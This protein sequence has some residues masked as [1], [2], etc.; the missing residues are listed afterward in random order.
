ML[1]SWLRTQTPLIENAMG[2]Q[3]HDKVDSHKTLECVKH[4]FRKYEFQKANEYYYKMPFGFEIVISGDERMPYS[5]WR[6]SADTQ[7]KLTGI[8]KCATYVLNAVPIDQF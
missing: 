3:F 4:S 8:N 7:L 5:C 6:Y 1:V 2:T